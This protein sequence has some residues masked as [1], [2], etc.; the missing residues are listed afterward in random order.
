MSLGIEMGSINTGLPKDIVKQIMEAERAPIAKMESR[1]EKINDKKKLIDELSKLTEDIRGFLGVNGNAKGLRE[2]KVQTNNDIIDVAVDKN[3]AQPTNHQIEVV[4]LAQKSSAISN[5]FEDKDK[6]YVGVGYIQYSMP[7]GDTK[8]V[9]VD[10]SHASLNGIAQLINETPDMGMSAQVVNDGSG[11]DNPWRLLLSL[12]DTGS[13]NAVEFPYFYFVDGEDDLVLDSQREAHNAKVKLDG[14]EL[15]FPE[16]KL[17]DLIPGM[18]ID[19]KKAKPGEEFSLLVSEDVQAV[20]SKVKDLVDKMNAV[21]A[22]IKKQNTLDGK[23]DTSRTLGGDLSLQQLESRLRSAVFS[24]IQT[25]WGAKRFG[26]LGV[27]FQ[28][29]GTLIFEEKKF[30]AMSSQNYQMVSQILTGRY[31]NGIKERGAMDIMTD[32][33][34]NALRAPDGLLASRKKSFQGNIDQID[35]QIEN[36]QRI[37]EQ[38]ERN[39]KD[40]FSR[41]EGTISKIKGQAAGIAGLAGGA[42]P[43]PG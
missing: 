14:F 20:T 36:K 2:L 42:G 24:D 32:T 10:S 12:K 8:E 31:N 11:E 27:T 16:N 4:Q 13:G 38:K 7:N 6:S 29:D 43:M 30:T 3:L 40:K 9:Y 26:D 33:V 25:D 34:N 37:L 41:L 19:L 35:K 17:K 5:G 1:K 21:L 22:F 18:T 23:S 15:E 28:K 39:L